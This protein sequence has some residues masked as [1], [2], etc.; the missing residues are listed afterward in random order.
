[1]RRFATWLTGAML[2]SALVPAAANAAT[3]ASK[4]QQG[5]SLGSS[6]CGLTD[7]SVTASAC[8]GWYE[9]N[10]NGGSPAMIAASTEALRQ[11]LGS[12][13]V[14][15]PLTWLEDLTASG[16]SVNFSTPL[17][18]TTVV[19]FHVGA[20]KGASNGV[21]YQ[22]TAFYVFD[23]GNSASGLDQ[24][25]FNLAGLSNARLYS[26]GSYIPAVP[27][28]ATWAMLLAGVGLVGGTMR[29]R[30]A[31]GAKIACA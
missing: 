1:M 5:L 17:Y 28:P 7:I 2:A 4:P 31:V 27:E 15:S 21:G 18:G 30:R 12:A 20:A 22:G 11:L 25:T 3:I 24:F 10:L 14:T 13:S 16:S 29:R 9:R 8:V 6:A 19:S 26:T 23:A